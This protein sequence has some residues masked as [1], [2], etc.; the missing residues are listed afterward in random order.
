MFTG[1]ALQ[2]APVSI[3]ASIGKIKLIG[4]EKSEVRGFE[5]ETLIEEKV[6]G[7]GEAEKE[8]LCVTYLVFLV[9]CHIRIIV[10]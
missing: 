5:D 4:T 10:G 6:E 7:L 2:N 1:I 9:L 8:G 3:R